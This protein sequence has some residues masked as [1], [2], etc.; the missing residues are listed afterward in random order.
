MVSKTIG[1]FALLSVHLC[2]CNLVV[3]HR[4]SGQITGRQLKKWHDLFVADSPRLWTHHE[5]KLSIL[6]AMAK[7]INRPS[8]HLRKV[9]QCC[10]EP[11]NDYAV[12]DSSEAWRLDCFT[13][14]QRESLD[15]CCT[16]IEEEDGRMTDLNHACCSRSGVSRYRCFHRNPTAVVACYRPYEF[17]A[18]MY[19]IRDS[20]ASD[21]LNSGK[22]RKHRFE[23]PDADD[24]R[25]QFPQESSS[26][27]SSSSQEQ[28]QNSLGAGTGNQDDGR[29]RESTSGSSESLED[30]PN[31]VQRQNHQTSSSSSSSSSSSEEEDA[32]NLVQT[33]E[34]EDRALLEKVEGLES[35][36][37]DM[38]SDHFLVPN[39]PGTVNQTKEICESD[40]EK[41]G[42][43]RK[44][45]KIGAYV[46][47]HYVK[48]GKCPYL[49]CRKFF[50]EFYR[51]HKKCIQHPFACGHFFVECCVR[52]HHRKADE[53]RAGNVMR[54]INM[55]AEPIETA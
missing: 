18:S 24:I 1:L 49:Q 33:W 40:S 54:E 48:R 28:E 15:M 39:L 25:F 53:E 42:N 2:L 17:N 5:D 4:S 43:C 11:I 32:E 41:P 3:D 10:T 34:K 31:T 30:L 45:C 50:I 29:E 51:K 12:R 26:S 35:E 9:L 36:C 38:D 7:E 55:L 46:G 19:T 37:K 6:C 14:M 20:S 21:V 44:C 47:E 23:V 8:H 52:H 22:N 16:F 27:S 13:R